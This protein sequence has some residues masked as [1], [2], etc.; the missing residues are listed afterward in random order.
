MMEE[1]ARR[2]QL[3]PAEVERRAPIRMDEMR[4]A[5]QALLDK[6][7]K[8]WVLPALHGGVLEKKPKNR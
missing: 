1:T 5:K 4:A 7:A 3:T 8:M 6:G 2:V